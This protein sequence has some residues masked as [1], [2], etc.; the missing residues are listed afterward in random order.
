[1]FLNVYVA[2]RL[3]CV[4][5]YLFTFSLSYCF[6]LNLVYLSL[7]HFSSI[8]RSNFYRH[9]FELTHS[10]KNSIQF[11]TTVLVLVFSFMIGM[12]VTFREFIFIEL[13]NNTC[14]IN[15]SSYVTVGLVLMVNFPLLL[16]LSFYICSILIVS[17]SNDAAKSSI[18]EAKKN[19]KAFI[20]SVKFLAFSFIPLFAG[21]VR[22]LLFIL[23]MSCPSC[24]KSLYDFFQFFLFFSFMIEP[25]ILI[26]V[27]NI[28]KREAKCSVLKWLGFMGITII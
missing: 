9:L 11:I 1:L 19:R 10:V 18:T 24:N 3:N 8:K 14:K 12:F 13:N 21:I 17:F 23:P 25:L 6:N 15:F 2:G 16:V 26:S 20:I 27:H 4:I 22:N 7:Y 5:F 28:L